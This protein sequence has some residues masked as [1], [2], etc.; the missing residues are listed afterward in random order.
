MGVKTLKVIE[1]VRK[2]LQFDLNVSIIAKLNIY[3]TNVSISF[4]N[5][6]KDLPIAYARFTG[7][8]FPICLYC[9]DKLPL[10]IH[11]SGK[12]CI[13][14][15]SRTVRGRFSVGWHRSVC[16]IAGEHVK[17][18]EGSSK[19]KRLAIPVFLL[20]YQN[21]LSY[22]PFVYLLVDLSNIHP[23]EPCS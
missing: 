20:P 19:C 15:Y 6:I 18:K 5:L 4:N 21:F 14:A 10:K 2:C 1:N 9:S 7:T 11:S 17:V 22:I 8:A 16:F 23:L 3:P 13:L 12:V